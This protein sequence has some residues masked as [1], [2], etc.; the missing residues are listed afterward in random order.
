MHRPSQ[1]VK[2]V[3][4]DG[5]GLLG[6]AERQRNQNWNK[7]WLRELENLIIKLPLFTRA[8][9]LLHDNPAGRVDVGD[10]GGRVEAALGDALAHLEYLGAFLASLTNELSDAR[11]LGLAIK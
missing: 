9:Y 5:D 10:D 7:N 3:V 6:S 1:P 4:G 2:S 11:T 8:K